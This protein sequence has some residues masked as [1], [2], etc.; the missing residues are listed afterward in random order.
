M[1]PFGFLIIALT[2]AAFSLNANATASSSQ[3]IIQKLMQPT[4]SGTLKRTYS[5]KEVL[6]NHDIRRHLSQVD[7]DTIVFRSNSAQIKPKDYGK[8]QDIAQALRIILSHNPREY[9]LIEGHTDAPGNKNYNKK[10]SY[11][12]AST[13]KQILVRGY[14][15]PADH[16][17]VAG[18]GEEFLKIKV[19]R[20]EPRNRRVTFRRITAALVPQT[21]A[22]HVPG[23]FM[24]ALKKRTTLPFMP[25]S[26][27]SPFA[28]HQVK[29]AAK[30]KPLTPFAPRLIVRPA[31]PFVPPN[32]AK[33][34]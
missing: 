29:P 23:S 5:V 16:L 15:I 3:K 33:P 6:D 7:I 18:Y 25:P 11:L 13:V 22:R 14:G 10:L 12:R 2:T 19:R 27:K 17:A 32:S 20:K 31:L 24:P 8:L 1:H 26:V 4:A 28:R 21:A 34:F 30:P 9:F